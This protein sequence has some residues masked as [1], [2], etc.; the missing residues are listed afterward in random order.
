MNNKKRELIKI[1]YYYY[2]L[3]MTQGKIAKKMSVSRQKVNRLIG[4]LVD[5]GIVNITI[6]GYEN[7][8][9]EMEKKIEKQYSLK[10]AI[11]I[12]NDEEENLIE[13]LGIA[14]ANYLDKVVKRGSTIGVS[15]GKTLSSVAENI[16]NSKK[17][18]I[19]VVQLVGGLNMEHRSINADEITRAI[20][21]AFNGKPN[22]M[23]A[24]AIVKD[25]NTKQ[26][27]MSD[28]SIKSIFDKIYECDMAMVGIGEL[29]RNA[30]LFKHNYLSEEDFQ[31]LKEENCVGDICSHYFNIEGEPVLNEINNRV[32][33]PSLSDLNEI[34]LVIGIAGGKEKVAAIKG[35]L[36]GRHLDVLITDN[37]VAK[38]IID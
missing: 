33:G 35:A 15:W 29:S 16:T 20:A 21:D 5:E 24:P 36:R 3:G 34:D 2:K 7:Y 14:G 19:S 8:Y 18:D 22:I 28:R 25:I 37:T 11:I 31:K 1:A 13:K 17:K 10:E 26:T 6:N 27:L 9:I 32:I 12:D 23:Y 38:N 4:T 30:T